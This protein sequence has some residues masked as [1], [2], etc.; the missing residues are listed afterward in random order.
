MPDLVEH[1]NR[2]YRKTSPERVSWFQPHLAQSL[3]LINA[4]HLAKDAPIIDVGGGASTLAS[5]LLYLGFT[6]VTVL[7]ISGEAIR[8]AKAGLRESAGLIKWAE[9][10]VLSPGLPS[11]HYDLWHDRAVF[12]FLV[13]ADDQAAYFGKMASALRREGHFVIGGFA[14]DG[15]QQCSGLPVARHSSAS[16]ANLLGATF[17][18]LQNVLEVH[19]TPTGVEQKFF[20]CDFRKKNPTEAYPPVDFPESHP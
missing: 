1:W 12:H 18:L 8:L 4:V 10:D 15:P 9:A 16:I 6:N 20:F 3:A 2:I 14:L 19:Y 13:A 5:D 17:E 7:D 11:N